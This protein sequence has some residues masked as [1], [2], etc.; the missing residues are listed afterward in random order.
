MRTRLANRRPSVT[1]R[2]PFIMADER[3]ITLTVTFGFDENGNVREVFCAD[4]KA[5]SDMHAAVMDACILLS[6]LLQHGDP[7]EELAK[8][9]C[10]PP[11]LVGCI[12]RAASLVQLDLFATQVEVLTG[13]S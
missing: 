6:R 13:D 10:E 8:T 11:S 7:P 3:Q 5:G 9:L 1:G 4:F 2:V 12:A